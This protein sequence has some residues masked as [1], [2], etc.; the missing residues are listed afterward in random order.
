MSAKYKELLIT[1]LNCHSKLLDKCR[2]ERSVVSRTLYSYP[3]L[4]SHPCLV[5]LLLSLLI[6]TSTFIL[7]FFSCY[8]IIQV[9][10]H[11]FAFLNAF[12][13]FAECCSNGFHTYTCI[14]VAPQNQ[15]GLQ[16][17]YL[18]VITCGT[19]ILPVLLHVH[20][21]CTCISVHIQGLKT[22]KDYVFNKIHDVHL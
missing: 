12:I 1:F 19:C 2:N 6:P 16:C 8:N 14:A 13:T 22:G 10:L 7:F 15:Y 21:H 11:F 4:L 5:P 9:N 3:S 18:C 20:V 17:L